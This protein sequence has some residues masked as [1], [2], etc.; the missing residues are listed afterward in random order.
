EVELAALTRLV[1]IPEPVAGFEPPRRH[2][3]VEHEPSDLLRGPVRGQVVI[4]PR[5]IAG[6]RPRRGER[7]HQERRGE[8]PRDRPARHGQLLPKRRW[9]KKTAPLSA[10]STERCYTPPRL[11]DDFMHP[12]ARWLDR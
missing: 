8:A 7:D 10:I 9:R 3:R 1:R 4:R 2:G 6:L 12:A 5:G 11:F